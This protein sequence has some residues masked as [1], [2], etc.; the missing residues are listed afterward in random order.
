MSILVHVNLASILKKYAKGNP[1]GFEVHLPDHST[2][3]DLIL[4]LGM[5]PE[6]VGTAMINGQ[7]VETSRALDNG[8]Q[9]LL[10]PLMV[11]GG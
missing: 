6:M 11:A 7:R 4:A 5:P 10:W 1:Q 2:V 3:D 9:V 8:D